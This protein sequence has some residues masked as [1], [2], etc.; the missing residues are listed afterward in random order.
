MMLQTQSLMAKTRPTSPLTTLITVAAVVGALIFAKEILL[1]LALAILLSFVLTPIATRIERLGL[2]RIGSVAVVV[3]LSLALLGGMAWIVTAQ[4][5]QLGRELPDYKNNIVEKI[6]SI[7]PSSP[8]F[9]RFTSALAEV[10]QEL[11]GEPRPKKPNRPTTASEEKVAKQPAGSTGKIAPA[12]GDDLGEKLVAVK[13]V[14]MPPSP[15]TTIQDWLGPLVGPLTTVGIVIVLVV[16][17]LVQREEHR[18]RLIRLF[19]SANLHITTEVIKD[20]SDRISRYLLMQFLINTC[21]GILVALG[22]WLLGV[23]SA[24]TWGVMSFALRFLPYVGPWIAAAMPVA[25]SLAVSP[26]WT[27]PLLVIAWYVVLEMIAG[28]LVEPYLYGHSIGVSGLGIILAAISWTWLWGP[29]GLVVAMPL[30]VCLVVTAQYIPQLRFIS[31]LIGDQPT[32]SLHERIYQRLLAFDEIEPRKLAKQ[33]L[34]EETLEAFYDNVLIPVLVLAER[35]RHNDALNDDQ[36]EFVEDAAED[37]VEELGAERSATVESSATEP[38]ATETSTARVLCIPLRD[39]ADRTCALMMSQLLSVEGYHV[40]IG[41]SDSLTTEIVDLIAAQEIDVAVLSAVPPIAP[42]QTRLL[43]QRLRSR[44]P[45]LPIVVGVWKSGEA[46]KMFEQLDLDGGSHYAN[47]LSEAIHAV[48]RAANR[49]DLA[50]RPT[51][52]PSLTPAG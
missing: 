47:T 37:L 48:K 14:E 52:T 29:I 30:T 40:E 22:L 5:V 16:F 44:Y 4:L 11:L 1:P 38:T 28:N 2:G 45:S 13:V 19:G 50:Q 33:Y 27:Q 36:A 12:P 41:S 23:P 6:K 24:V 25:I 42:R 17:M 8:A 49:I 31:V 51:D 9:S 10:N 35:D 39:R 7:T 26:G 3:V 32:L 46:G 21:Y 20:V 43:R 15:L 34:A 18:N